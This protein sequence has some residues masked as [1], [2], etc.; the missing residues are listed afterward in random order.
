MNY[1]IA[2]NVERI[3]KFARKIKCTSEGNKLH[4]PV[5]RVSDVVNFL[6]LKKNRGVNPL[7]NQPD[8][9]LSDS[10]YEANRD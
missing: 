2:S 1:W 10:G 5:D 7:D 6:I 3:N 9:S 8:T 4:I